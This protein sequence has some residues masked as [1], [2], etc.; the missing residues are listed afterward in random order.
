MDQYQIVTLEDKNL[1]NQRS[2]AFI[3]DR[4]KVVSHEL[5][6][7]NRVRLEYMKA[8]NIIDP[9]AQGNNFLTEILNSDKSINEQ[10]N[11]IE[12]LKLIADYLQDKKSAYDPVPSN[13]GV[14][15]QTLS[16]MIAAY[17]VAQLEH[18]SLL[19]A[20]VPKENILVKQKEEQLRN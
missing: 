9:E 20:N 17:N 11:Q 7:I 14:A 16:T 8:N 2:K 4:L 3:D 13:L 10:R 18:K 15:D 12:V 6:S 19:D 5:D 1:A